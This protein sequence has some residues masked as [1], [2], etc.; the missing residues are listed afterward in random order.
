MPDLSSSSARRPLPPDL[1]RLLHDLRGPLNA[2]VIHAEVLKRAASDR[3][4]A[5]QSVH[6]ILQQL[7]RL[8]EMLEAA[9]GV[10][11][12]ERGEFRSIDLRALVA[13]VVK[14]PV[15]ASVAP[16]APPWPAVLGDEELLRLAI[17]SLLASALEATALAGSPRAPEVSAG[18][19]DAGRVMLHVR[20][21]GAGS[22]SADAKVRIRDRGL[23]R[24]AVERIAR[25]HGGAL[26]FESTAGGSL[27]TLTLPA[28]P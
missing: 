1:D 15:L 22:G 3:A 24:V 27:A 2:A 14:D 21:W 17:R 26:T 18:G 7:G 13:A 8:G 19:P 5:D 16:S 12:L 28:A 4:A 6:A 25:L 11:A 10:V 20:D 23:G 9:F